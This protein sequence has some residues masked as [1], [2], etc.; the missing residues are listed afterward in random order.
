MVKIDFSTAISVY[1]SVSLLLVFLQWIFY[2]FYRSEELD[3]QTKHFQRC[4]Y[5]TYT[6]FYYYKEGLI[7]CPRCQSIISKS[8]ERES[9]VHNNTET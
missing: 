8:Q 1:L 5:C 6:F 2:N 9:H 7:I 4:P 3:F